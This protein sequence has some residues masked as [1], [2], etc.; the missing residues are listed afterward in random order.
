MANDLKEEDDEENEASNF[1][2]PVRNPVR[3]SHGW[4]NENTPTS[5]PS[6]QG[7]PRGAAGRFTK[8]ATTLPAEG[9]TPSA[10]TKSQALNRVMMIENPMLHNTVGGGNGM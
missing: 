9:N 7:I 1:K 5:T 6:T 10:G 2:K 8:Q 4:G 3:G